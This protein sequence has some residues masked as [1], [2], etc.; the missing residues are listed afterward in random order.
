MILP[1]MNCIL[2]HCFGYFYQILT[3]S[4]TLTDMSIQTPVYVKKKKKSYEFSH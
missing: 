4:M 1:M 3:K 2:R